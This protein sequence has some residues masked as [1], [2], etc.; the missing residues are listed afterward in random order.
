M[1]KISIKQLAKNATIGAA[2]IAGA[3]IGTA[4]TGGNPIGGIVG[5]AIGGAVTKKLADNFVE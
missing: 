3:S 1:G 2:G 5:G 4:V